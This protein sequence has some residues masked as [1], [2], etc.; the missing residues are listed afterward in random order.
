M[1][2]TSQNTTLYRRNSWVLRYTV[3]DEDQ[4]GEPALDVSAYDV[5][6]SICKFSLAGDPLTEQLLVDVNSADNPLV[7]V[8]VDAVN[9]V[10]EIRL[11][12]TVTEALRPGDYYSEL[13]V[14]DTLGNPVVCA[15][16]TITVLP[17]NRNVV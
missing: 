6:F 14:F 5:Y 10:V 2:K 17:N 15:T 16:G 7:V 4:P 12:A 8:K 11:N 1:A 9:G 13:E 3:V